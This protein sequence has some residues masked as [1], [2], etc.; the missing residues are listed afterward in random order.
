MGVDHRLVLKGPRLGGEAVDVQ[1]AQREHELGE[2]PVQHVAVD[3]DIG[4]IVVEAYELRLVVYRFKDVRRP[5]PYAVDD[6]QVALGENPAGQRVDG[7]LYLGDVRE[8]VS[9]FCELYVPFQVRL[10]EGEFVRRYP[11][12]L[13]YLGDY[14]KPDDPYPAEES[15]AGEIDAYGPP[16]RTRKGCVEEK[17]QATRKSDEGDIVRGQLRVQ[18]GPSRSV[19]DST[20]G[21][22]ELVPGDNGPGDKD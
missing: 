2:L 3:V 21:I 6:R 1:L 19:D 7:K 8:S 9:F 20:M 14:P 15:R 16:G 5:E 18:V 17:D 4:E 11:E 10:F 22:E 13:D 12:V